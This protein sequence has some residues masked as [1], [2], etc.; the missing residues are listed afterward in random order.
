MMFS[1]IKAG[2]VR[3]PELAEL[4]RRTQNLTRGSYDLYDKNYKT[5]SVLLKKI[6]KIAKQENE[7]YVYFYA[8]KDLMYMDKRSAHY[9]YKEIVKYAEVYYKDSELY[10]DRELPNYPGTNMATLN[11]WICGDIFDTYSDCHQIDDTKMEAFMR[12]YEETTRKYGNE[13]DYYIAEMNMG[14]LY[15]DADRAKKAAQNFLKYEKDITSCYVCWHRAYLK[16]FLLC[17]QDR[18][19]EELMLDLI[20]KNIPKQHLWCYKYCA[21][22]EPAEMYWTVLW[23][24]VHSG[25][26]A[27][28]DYFFEKYWSGLPHENRRNSDSGSFSRL[29]CAVANDFEGYEDDLR[30][31][32]EDIDDEEQDTA[33]GNMWAYLEWWCY[34]AL[35][36]RSGI[37]ELPIAIPAL[38]TGENGLVST[39]AVST[40]M[41][42]KAD[43]FGRQFAQARAAFDYEF[44]KNAYRKCFL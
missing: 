32:L 39:L 19:A 40:Y 10:M 36:D 41:E 28:F 17:G 24:C 38:E 20:H 16:H 13:Y 14:I 15:Q 34:Y 9:N 43:T 33:V 42:K 27:S 31:T 23:S 4:V 26:K 7:W 25:K 3:T 12:K 22:A 1:D 11:V 29:L 2:T 8:L 18:Q 6:L 21:N 30:Q 5:L 35:L 37:H 44:A